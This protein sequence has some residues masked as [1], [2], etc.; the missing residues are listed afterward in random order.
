MRSYGPYGT[1]HNTNYLDIEISSTG[2][3]VSVWFR[4]QPLPFK[5]TCVDEQRAK[6][7]TKMSLDVNL[8]IK[9]LGVVVEP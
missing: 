2:R 4:C 6:D 8:N 1:I 7:M 3:I 9:L 5:Q